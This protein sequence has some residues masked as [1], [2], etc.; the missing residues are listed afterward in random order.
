MTFWE[1]KNK[2][3][4]RGIARKICDFHYDKAAYE[5]M[6]KHKT[7]IPDFHVILD[8]YYEVMKQKLELLKGIVTNE[9]CKAMLALTEEVLCEENF[10]EK[11]KKLMPESGRA[12]VVSH[13]DPKAMNWLVQNEDNTNLMLVDYE[14]CSFSYETHDLAYFINNMPCDYEYEGEA[15][16]KY[17]EENEITEE[18]TKILCKAYLKRFY[19]I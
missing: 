19:E 15:K 9:E 4:L 18:E 10:I 7:K 13:G 16:Y 3:F 11:V 1:C 6:A 17:Y 8:T 14:F 12:L 5:I 2:V